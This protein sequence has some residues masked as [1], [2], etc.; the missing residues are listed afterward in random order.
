MSTNE[1]AD[2]RALRLPE[3]ARLLGVGTAE[4][5]RLRRTGLL[6][7]VGEAPDGEELFA[8]GEYTRLRFLVDLLHAG[9]TPAMLRELE[10]LRKDH[11]VASR[12]A[13]RLQE[14]LIELIVQVTTRVQRLTALREDLV[15]G[16][17]ALHRCRACHRAFED[18]PCGVCRAMPLSPP[19]A[20]ALFFL[21]DKPATGA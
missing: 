21:P 11:R 3:M 20:L 2:D 15:Q 19:H 7:P 8:A 5:R 12:A 4:V 13:R 18:L 1:P 6:A 17:E 10:R 14:K 9:A 16:R